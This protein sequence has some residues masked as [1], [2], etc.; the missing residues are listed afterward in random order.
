MSFTLRVAA[1]V[2]IA[3]AIA[4]GG[5]VFATRRLEVGLNERGWNHAR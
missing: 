3:I 2:I 4:G 5:G 1:Y